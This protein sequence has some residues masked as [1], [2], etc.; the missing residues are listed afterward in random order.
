[1]ASVVSTRVLVLSLA[2]CCLSRGGRAACYYPSGLQA[3]ND[4]PCRDDTPHSTCCG[5]GYA[6]LSNGICQATGEELQKP[7]A[8]EFVRGSCTDKQWR[9]SSCPLFCITEDYDY[10]DG[11]MGMM[12]CE[13]T[14]DDMYFC[15]NGQESSCEDQYNVLYFPGT[16]SVITTIGVAPSTTSSSSSSSSSSPTTDTV[17]PSTSQDSSTA[18]SPGAGGPTGSQTPPGDDDGDDDDDSS[19]SSTNVGAIVGGVIGGVAIVALTGAGGW[20]LAKKHARRAHGSGDVH[21][22]NGTAMSPSSQKLFY[23]AAPPYYTGPGEA[24]PLSPPYPQQQQQQNP[25]GPFEMAQPQTV[26]ELAS[27]GPLEMPTDYHR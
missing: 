13:N 17:S 14:S 16:P 4:T 18:T 27:S 1:M 12:K 15:I 7:G 10:L 26:P 23:A 20:V 5:Q 2:L 24:D 3:P 11:G 21:A 25:Y 8:T 19:S 9:S 22:N 6:C